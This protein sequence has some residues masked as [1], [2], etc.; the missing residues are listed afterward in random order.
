MPS[1]KTSNITLAPAATDRTNDK[2]AD[3][4]SLPPV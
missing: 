4:L 3:A 2:C 1:E